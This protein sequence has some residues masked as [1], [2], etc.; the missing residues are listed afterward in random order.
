[1]FSYPDEK[2]NLAISF[3]IFNSECKNI[4]NEFTLKKPFLFNLDKKNYTFLNTTLSDIKK[5]ITNYKNKVLFSRYNTIVP[6]QKENNKN[7]YSKNINFDTVLKLYSTDKYNISISQDSIL[8]KLLDITLPSF[9]K[10]SFPLDNIHCYS[11]LNLLKQNCNYLETGLH[12]DITHN[13]LIQIH[14]SK[15][16]RLYEPKCS[17]NLY[18]Q[19]F[20]SL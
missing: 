6:V 1:M 2:Y 11:W 8:P 3:N 20:Y 5:V 19:P 4:Y 16:V 14:G 13:I 7:I 15:V 18:I 9:I 10:N 12:Y 17:K